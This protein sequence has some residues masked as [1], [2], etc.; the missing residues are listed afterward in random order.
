M[1]L[2]LP[3]Q[4]QVFVTISTQ[5]PTLVTRDDGFS[6]GVI[7]ILT[8]FS[9]AYRGYHGYH[10]VT[11]YDGYYVV[12]DYYGYYVVTIRLLWLPCNVVTMVT[13]WLLWL[14]CGYN[15]VTN[16]SGYY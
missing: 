7:M 15:V 5:M 3:T 14:Q 6:T 11:S 1:G 16:Y 9:T 12:T 2:A 10:V 8:Y 13:M 4:V